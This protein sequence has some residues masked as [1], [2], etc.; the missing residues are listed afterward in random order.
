MKDI[1]VHNLSERE[2]F[3]AMEV[4]RHTY[5][6]VC[7]QSD[8]SDQDAIAFVFETVLACMAEYLPKKRVIDLPQEA[9]DQLPGSYVKHYGHYMKILTEDPDDP[10]RFICATE[11]GRLASY[12]K[13]SIKAPEDLLNEFGMPGISDIEPEFKRV[14]RAI[15]E[16]LDAR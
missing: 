7:S 2:T 13:D 14:S 5:R 4:V 10:M 15:C 9:E 1:F 8:A 11:G 16:A 6:D 12:P 3:L